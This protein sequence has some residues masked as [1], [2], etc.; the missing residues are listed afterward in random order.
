MKQFHWLKLLHLDFHAKS[1]LRG[2]CA[3]LASNFLKIKIKNIAHALLLM[4]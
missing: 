4:E 2:N 1:G 3:F